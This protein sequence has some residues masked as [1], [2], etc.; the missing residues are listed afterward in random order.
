MRANIAATLLFLAAIFLVAARYCL[1]AMAS[2]LLAPINRQQTPLHFLD[3]LAIELGVFA[4]NDALDEIDRE[5]AAGATEPLPQHSIRAPH[6]NA[7]DPS[8]HRS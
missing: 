5:N 2:A 6:V 3:G 1:R 7:R 4:A 8:S